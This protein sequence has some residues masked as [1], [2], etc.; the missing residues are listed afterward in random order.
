M[1]PIPTTIDD[2][3][4]YK[5]KFHYV[6]KNANLQV[7]P[8]LYHLPPMSAFGD[9]LTLPL[10]DLRP[11]L[12]AD[13][14]PYKLDYRSFTARRAPSKLH[15]APCSRE[16]WN[17]PELIRTIYV[18]E[19]EDLVKRVTGC[20]TALVESAVIRNHLHLEIDSHPTE[21]SGADYTG[22]DAGP[23][24]RMIGFSD[25]DGASPAPKVHLDFSPLGARTHIRKY[26][27]NLAICCGTR[28]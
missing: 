19:V 27:R 1:S 6:S 8:N 24:P 9:A 25:A 28:Y 21:K 2:T 15:S 3:P 7:N 14:S 23:C 17:D 11:S 13:E 10:A 20:K 18:P 5:G 16:S 12:D 26:H 4:Q 22:D